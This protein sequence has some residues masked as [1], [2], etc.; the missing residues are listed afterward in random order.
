MSTEKKISQH[1]YLISLQ[2]PS[3]PMP[4][5]YYLPPKNE[6]NWPYVAVLTFGFQDLD[7]F[8]VFGFEF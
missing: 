6:K 7:G 1:W 8:R 2:I 4:K 3:L 5:Q